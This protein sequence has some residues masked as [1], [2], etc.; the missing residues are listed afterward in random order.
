MRS[1]EDTHRLP[2]SDVTNSFVYL[3]RSNQWQNE[4]VLFESG[5]LVCPLNA[6]VRQTDFMISLFL[7]VFFAFV[8][9]DYFPISYEFVFSDDLS[10]QMIFSFLLFNTIFTIVL[11]KNPQITKIGTGKI[12]GRRGKIQII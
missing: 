11:H 8:V 3:Q 4:K 12:C 5:A 9:V 1:H 7:L 2:F 6:K 10:I